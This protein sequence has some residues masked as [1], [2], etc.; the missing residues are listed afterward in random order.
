M[1]ASNRSRIVVVAATNDKLGASA[2][3]EVMSAAEI[4]H[5][6]VEHD[7]STELLK[8]FEDVGVCV[9]RASPAQENAM[10]G[11]KRNADI[12]QTISDSLRKN[13]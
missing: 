13:R 11:A 10:A 6:I 12:V 2:P 4:D 5:L 1:S 9:H 7:T 3:F 8:Y